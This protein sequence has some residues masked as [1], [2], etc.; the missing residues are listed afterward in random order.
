M[1]RSS[2]KYQLILF[3][4]KYLKYILFTCPRFPGAEVGELMSATCFVKKVLLEQ[5]CSFICLLSML[6]SCY[7]SSRVEWLQQTCMHGSHCLKY[8]SSGSLQKMF[9]DHCSRTFISIN[10]HG[11]HQCFY[12]PLKVRY[13]SKT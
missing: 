1:N 8:F 7:G 12:K 3:S 13:N 6:L 2:P 9:A 4:F 5:L 11:S 10:D